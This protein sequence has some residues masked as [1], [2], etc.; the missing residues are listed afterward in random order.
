[1]TAI[2]TGNGARWFSSKSVAVSKSSSDETSPSSSEVSND[3]E[4]ATFC[5]PPCR[6]DLYLASVAP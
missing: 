6:S 2:V 4:S 5:E 3:V 1:V